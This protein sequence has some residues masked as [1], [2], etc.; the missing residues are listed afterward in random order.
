MNLH[1]E[2]VSKK[3]LEVQ[4]LHIK[5][6]YYQKPID[7]LSVWIVLSKFSTIFWD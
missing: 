2:E 6:I 4:R 1:S 3:A 7:L 5:F